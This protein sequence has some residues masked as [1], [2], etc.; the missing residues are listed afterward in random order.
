[1]KNMQA[2][3]RENIEDLLL[4]FVNEY[5]EKFRDWTKFEDGL[6]EIENNSLADELAEKCK[7]LTNI[8]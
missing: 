3:H 2:K 5:H 1:M 6:R 4:D 8:P 7:H